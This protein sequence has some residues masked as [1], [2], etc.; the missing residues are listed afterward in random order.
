MGANILI[1]FYKAV[2]LVLCVLLA[3]SPQLM[4]NDKLSSLEPEQAIPS[5][6][7]HIDRELFDRSLFFIENRGQYPD[8]SSF[9]LIQGLTQISF[10]DDRVEI[11]VTDPSDGTSVPVSM[12]LEGANP[13]R[14]QGTDRTPSKMNYIQGMDESR[15]FQNVPCHSKIIYTNIYN[16]IDLVFYFKGN[17][18]KYDFI[19]GPN[20]DPGDISVRWSGHTDLSISQASGDLV[21]DTEAGQLVDQAPYVYSDIPEGMVEVD[22]R[23]VTRGD[24]VSYQIGMYDQR[25]PL[26]IDP[27]INFSTLLSESLWEQG[28]DIGADDEG[29]CYVT[30]RT[31]STNFPTTSGAFNTTHSGSSD[32]FVTKLNKDGT[33]LVFS[34]FIGGS[35]NDVANGIEVDDEGNIYVVGSTTSNDFPVTASAYNTTSN[36]LW[37]AFVL[38]LDPTGSRL[39]YSTYIG[40]SNDDLG[41]DIG[42]DAAGA[43]YVAGDTLSDD[44]PTTPGA[45]NRTKVFREE[46]FVTKLSPDGSSLEYSTLVSGNGQDLTKAMVVDGSGNVFVTGMTTSNSFPIT[47]G[48]FRS[49]RKLAEGFVFKLNANGSQLLYSTFLGGSD[50]DWAEGIAVDGSGNAYVC[51]YT[52]SPDF[53]TTPGVINRTFSTGTGSPGYVAKLNWNG[54]AL[55]YSTFLGGGN[56]VMAMALAVDPRGCV[57]VTGST[58]SN[59]LPTTLGAYDMTFNGSTDVFVM[60]LNPTASKVR[61]CTYIGNNS[62]EIAYGICL[63]D[64]ARAYVTGYTVGLN[65]PTTPNAYDRTR[66][67]YQDV[68]VFKLD[69]LDPPGL[70]G[71]ASATIATT[72]DPFIFNVTARDNLGVGTVW[73]R[74]WQGQGQGRTNVTLELSSGTVENGTWTY[75]IDIPPDSTESLHY[76]VHVN[77]TSGNPSSSGQRNVPVRDNDD[78]KID[79]SPVVVTGTGDEVQIDATLTDNVGIE[80][81]RVVMWWGSDEGKA[82]ILR[83]VPRNVHPNGTGEYRASFTVPSNSTEP[84]SYYLITNDT[85]KNSN[86]TATYVLDVIDNDPPEFIA[87]RSDTWATTG[88]RFQF[89]IEV[90]DNIGIARVHLVHWWNDD[91]D[92]SI[93]TTLIGV[94]LSGQGNGTYPYIELIIP[95]DR[96]DVLNYSF[97]ALD[98]NGNWQ[99]TDVKSVQVED[100]DPPEVIAD[101]SDRYAWTGNTFHFQA[102]VRENVAVY[103]VNV[104]FDFTGVGPDHLEMVPIGEDDSGN[105]IYGADITIPPN[106]VGQL[107]YSFECNDTNG[108]YD[109]VNDT[110][111]D[112]LDDDPPELSMDGPSELIKGIEA[113]LEVEVVD[114][115]GIDGVFI[116]YWY[117]D[118]T[119]TNVSII[120][121]SGHSIT[122]QIPRE[123]EGPLSYR[124][125]AEDE[126]GNWNRTAT[127]VVELINDPP[128]FI[129]VPT[130]NVTEESPT[131]LDLSV[132]ILDTNDGVDRLQLT[133]NEDGLTIDGLSISVIFMD[134]VEDHTIEVHVT[135]GEDSDTVEILI[136]VINVND[137]ISDL[138]IIL[139]Q[140]N[141]EYKEGETVSFDVSFQDPDIE[142]GQRHDLTWTS[143][144]SGV[145]SRMRSD[146]YEI[147]Q[148]D[149]LMPGVHRITIVIDDGEYSEEASIDI[150]IVESTDNGDPGGSSA[151]IWIL[152]LVVIV[153]VALLVL[154]L[155]Q[156]KD[157]S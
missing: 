122:L 17:D 27:A 154:M 120:S 130:W 10:F 95:I 42:I 19:V 45:F 69:D 119:P 22:G 90:R 72:G 59:D 7:G 109:E 128:R 141:D 30:G 125:S 35:Y 112:I 74:Y 65:F 138:T 39:L 6:N 50:T 14:P 156:K 12:A 132:Y 28:F 23:Y 9:K 106:R 134:W 145:I 115:I 103:M 149:H 94:N 57:V 79:H 44:F 127:V 55:E 8:S 63:D 151:L 24:S 73:V 62:L 16:L 56:G 34:T 66:G 88:E 123:Q 121:P 113:T 43:A 77:D 85:A 71:D 36:R 144:L 97:A 150:T 155:Y 3:S 29:N 140:D 51:G 38:K 11:R 20:G 136:H 137:P 1:P 32:A 81:A 67:G 148:V 61:Y 47:P 84:M 139:P 87:D 126:H 58:G 68:Y 143:S 46:V 48:A 114:N 53:P 75:S 64:A 31:E 117:G 146:E 5:L 49:T 82:A 108:N 153:V 96:M 78:P 98:L 101:G 2:I 152:I 91:R 15:W 93:N 131:T 76:T 40:G 133:S 83:L 142:A 116:E 104:L 100:N 111:L 89:S 18:L 110:I 37:D 157:G 33:D 52:E 21:I 86:R 4:V 147:V 13:V 26:V 60:K 70:L 102:T 41:I 129:E 124:F 105:I 25:Y 92:G 118:G 54:S 107:R 99:I 80:M 135:D